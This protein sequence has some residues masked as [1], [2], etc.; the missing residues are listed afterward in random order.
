MNDLTLKIWQESSATGAPI[1]KKDFVTSHTELTH[2][3]Y[4]DAPKD[5]AMRLGITAAEWD[6]V[7]SIRVLRSCVLSPYFGIPKV[8]E[9]YWEDFI[10]NMKMKLSKLL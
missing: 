8:T 9:Q 6:K 7:G 2:D 1:L 4:G 10:D 5:M 3:D